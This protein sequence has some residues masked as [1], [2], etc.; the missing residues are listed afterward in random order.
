M[1][2][3]LDVARD[4]TIPL[5]LQ[6]AVRNVTAVG[7]NCTQPRAQMLAMNLGHQPGLFM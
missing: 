6:S 4:M 2:F 5:P 1:K 7:A 3:R